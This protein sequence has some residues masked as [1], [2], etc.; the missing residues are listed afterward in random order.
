MK[1]MTTALAILFAVLLTALV[2]TG[3]M[4]PVR[5]RLSPFEL[6][7][8]RE[9]GE[10]T[11]RDELRQRRFGDMASLIRTAHAMILVLTVVTSVGLFGW[12]MGTL[13]GLM[14]VLIQGPLSRIRLVSAFAARLYGEQEATLLG[15][16]ARYKHVF[17]W[18]RQAETSGAH[19]FDSKEELEH[20]IIS[21]KGL[22][23]DEEKGLLSGSLRFED[24]QVRTI[25]TPKAKI[26]AIKKT[27]IL[28]PLVLDDLHR[29]GHDSF[30]VVNGAGLDEVVGV[31][32]LR[33]VQTLDT[34][35]KH[36]AKVETAMDPD[37]RVINQDEPLSVA[38][39][40]L[41]DSQH[42]L[43]IVTDD[44]GRTAGLVTLGDI[45]KVLFGRSR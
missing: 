23:T 1:G 42:H 39:R 36:T 5:P 9:L 30:P 12:V 11:A 24:R 44:E 32:R 16:A 3:A 40:V 41:L 13:V 15:I 37:V 35:R 8:R 19:G 34:A 7:R 14:T 18:F 29:S 38:L 4:A 31:L 20:M 10:D 43:L 26:F 17:K 25:M 6:K 21:S 33:D 45:I 22:L 28:G 27:E 2:L